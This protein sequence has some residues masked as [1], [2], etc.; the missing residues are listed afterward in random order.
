MDDPAAIDVELEL[1]QRY[2][3]SKIR[4]GKGHEVCGPGGKLELLEV[5][6]RP[7]SLPTL[8]SGFSVILADEV[9]CLDRISR[10]LLPHPTLS[11]SP[12]FVSLPPSGKRRDEAHTAGSGLSGASSRDESEEERSEQGSPSRG[13]RL[14][15]KD[16]SRSSSRVKVI[17]NHGSGPYVLSRVITV[18][19]NLLRPKDIGLNCPHSECTADVSSAYT[20]TRFGS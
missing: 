5:K 2:I 17:D 10:S 15:V 19:E 20:S 13:R 3:K 1:T 18:E 8:W 4:K 6:V 11:E 16:L 9:V 7:P 14:S 12:A